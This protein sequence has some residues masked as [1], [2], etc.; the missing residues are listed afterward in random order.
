MRRVICHYHIFKNSGTSFDELLKKN[1]GG[2]FFTFDGPF[3]FF[4]ISQDELARVIRNTGSLA[5]SCH[6]L[7]LPVPAALECEVLPVVFVRHPMLR[8]RSVYQF[9]K[10][11]PTTTPGG[12]EAGS[13][14]FEQWVLADHD[15]VAKLGAI[16]NEQTR[17]LGAT[18]GKEGLKRRTHDRGFIGDI[19]QARRNL[20]AVE[21][22]ARTEFYQRDVLGFE[23]ILAEK[24]L[25]FKYHDLE[26]S[27]TTS[28]DLVA[29]IDERLD[30][31]RDE[32]GSKTY[33]ILMDLNR[34]DLEL[35]D[36]A[37][38]RLDRAR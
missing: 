34:Q 13:M 3:P 12:E 15:N 5:Y 9:G 7:T 14:S 23:A 17:R 32:L 37:C 29:G 35:F 19:C 18:Y 6:Q 1:Y 11:S 38:Q 21:L 33:N 26:P 2:K 27:N 31:V 20:A 10:K 24:G 36:Y 25:S 28:T 22:L 8:I 30:N 16:S 4:K